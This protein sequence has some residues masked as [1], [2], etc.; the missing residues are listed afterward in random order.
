MAGSAGME[1]V[2]GCEAN[3]EAM[4][5]GGAEELA[6]LEACIYCN[7]CFELCEPEGYCPGGGDEGGC[8]AMF[9]GCLDCA[10]STC[11]WNYDGSVFTGVCAVEYQACDGVEDCMNLWNCRDDC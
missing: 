8:S 10:Y 5:G 6:A 9:S 1:G 4:Y 3:C 11:S 7:A 2:G